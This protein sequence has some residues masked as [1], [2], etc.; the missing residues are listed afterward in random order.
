[1]RTTYEQLLSP[2]VLARMLPHLLDGPYIKFVPKP[3]DI[4]E[5]A[6]KHRELLLHGTPQTKV[7]NA[8]TNSQTES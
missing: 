7:Q 6:R 5:C 2:P 1:M 8:T 4:F 3:P